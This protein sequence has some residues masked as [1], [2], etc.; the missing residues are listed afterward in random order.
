[1]GDE[2]SHSATPDNRNCVKIPTGD[3]TSSDEIDFIANKL[4]SRMGMVAVCGVALVPIC[5]G[6]PLRSSATSDPLYGDQSVEIS[7]GGI[8]G[9][10]FCAHLRVNIRFP[11]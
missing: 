4:V 6:S 2:G 9:R 3:N 7:M 8:Y 5:T 10:R 1:M 11:H